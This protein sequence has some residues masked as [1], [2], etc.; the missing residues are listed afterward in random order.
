MTAK[1]NIRH[2]FSHPKDESYDKVHEEFAAEN[3]WFSWTRLNGDT[4]FP[5]VELPAEVAAELRDLTNS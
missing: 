3:P 1:P 4:H 2:V 5:V